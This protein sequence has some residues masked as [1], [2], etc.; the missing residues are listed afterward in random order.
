MIFASCLMHMNRRRPTCFCFGCARAS[1]QP[2]AERSLDRGRPVSDANWG[3]GFSRYLRTS[4]SYRCGCS[5]IRWLRS[6]TRIES[7]PSVPRPSPQPDISRRPCACGRATTVQESEPRWPHSTATTEPSRGEQLPTFRCWA[8]GPLQRGRSS[9][10]EPSKKSGRRTIHAQE[11]L[12]DPANGVMHR[13]NDR[14]GRRARH[15]AHRLGTG[16]LVAAVAFGIVRIVGRRRG[17]ETT[18]AQWPAPSR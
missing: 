5:R 17:P 13:G 12:H 4:R 2:P 15:P 14:G 1:C 18:Q 3:D 7:R 6:L 9:P 10:R 11:S 8:T 16:L